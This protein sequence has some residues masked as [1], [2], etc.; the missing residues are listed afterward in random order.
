MIVDPNVE[1]VR[2]ASEKLIAKH[3]GLQ[4]WIRHLQDLEKRRKQKP[5]KARTKRSK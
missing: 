3:G 2:K 1:A 5:R 4:G